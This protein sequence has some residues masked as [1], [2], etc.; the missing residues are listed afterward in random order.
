MKAPARNSLIARLNEISKDTD[1][2]LAPDVNGLDN[3][4]RPAPDANA[5]SSLGN[6]RYAHTAFR[7]KDSVLFDD[8]FENQIKSVGLPEITADWPMEGGAAPVHQIPPSAAANVLPNDGKHAIK[9]RRSRSWASFSGGIISGLFAGWVLIVS[10]ATAFPPLPDMEDKDD[11][12]K[13]RFANASWPQTGLQNGAASPEGAPA[14]SNVLGTQTRLRV[15]SAETHEAAVKTDDGAI[16]DAEINSQIM[17]QPPG[18]VSVVIAAP[19]ADSPAKHI[20]DR[21]RNP[22]ASRGSMQQ[23]ANTSGDIRQQPALSASA[24]INRTEDGEE[25]KDITAKIVVTQVSDRVLSEGPLNTG[26]TSFDHDEPIIVTATPMEGAASGKSVSEQVLQKPEPA[27][28]AGNLPAEPSVAEPED[29]P[30]P[31]VTKS[32]LVADIGGLPP[33]PSQ[34]RIVASKPKASLQDFWPSAKRQSQKAL[35]SHLQRLKIASLRR[36]KTRKWSKS[37]HRSSLGMAKKK[38]SDVGKSTSKGKTPFVGNATEK[39]PQWAHG[40]MRRDR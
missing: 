11:F 30:P 17:S 24:D 8:T 35:Y 7:R 13:F 15:T 36:K 38:R 12:H 33:L 5:L 4:E 21:D 22:S 40:V 20:S 34:K 29:M 25:V 6:H 9:K 26:E 3:I 23:I 32:A 37:V 2:N 28:V 1:F 31:P 19:H 39:Y 14:G 10:V 27:Q 18:E 16:E